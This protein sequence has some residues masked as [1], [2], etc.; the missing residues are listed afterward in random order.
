MTTGNRFLRVLTITGTFLAAFTILAPLLLAVSHWVS[1]RRWLLDYLMPAEL[2]PV[3]ALGALLLIIAALGARAKRIWILG[4]AAAA[5][6][7][8]FGMQSIAVLTGM[9]SGRM[10]AAGW[11]HRAVIAAL[12]GYVLCVLLG[13]LGGLALLAE[14]GR[15]RMPDDAV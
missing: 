12:A 4:S 10:S 7:F 14:L 6:A 11:E 5:V 13:V 15:K 8:F 1:A 3:Y 2:F 9:A